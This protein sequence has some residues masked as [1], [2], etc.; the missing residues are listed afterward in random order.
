MQSQYANLDLRL[1][2]LHFRLFLHI[3]VL[4]FIYENRVAHAPTCAPKPQKHPYQM[5]DR[6]RQL[7]LDKAMSQKTFASELCIAEATLSGIFNGRTRPTNQ[8]VS[9]IHECFPEV[10]I[11]WLMFGEGDM[12]ASQPSAN[13]TSGAV[14]ED[15]CAAEE[16]PDLFSSVSTPQ[17]HPDA[18]AMHQERP[19]FAEQPLPGSHP[20]AHVPSAQVM[21]PQV[22]YIEK[23]IDKPQRKITEIRIFF[24]D[25]TYETFTP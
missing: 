6:I 4:G 13:D 9:A 19:A 12:Y 24:D 23:Y 17:G 7:M 16:M 1:E 14:Q 2:T 11:M 8:T 18:P 5:K 25:G 3:F 15:D 22:Q 21:Q 10:N 20:S